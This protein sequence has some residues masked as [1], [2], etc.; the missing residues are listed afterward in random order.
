VTA[1]AHP[2]SPDELQRRAADPG[3]SVWV[4]AS[5]GTGKTKVLTDRVLRLLLARR[6][7]QP[8][9]PSSLLC[10]TFTRAAAAEMGNRL[11]AR[12]AK[13]ASTDDAELA[14]DLESLFGVA[15]GEDVMRRARRLFAIVLDAPGGLA[16]ET[17]HG[18]CQSLLRR[19]PLEVE[20]PPHFQVMEERD[21]AEAMAA[22]REEMLSRARVGTDSALAAA[23]KIVTEVANEDAFAEL[24]RA[25]A[26]ER[27]RL[28]GLAETYGSLG[29]AAAELRRR[30]G[31]A[32]DE[33]EAAIVA[34]AVRDPAF[35]VEAMRAA[36]A[37]LEGGSATDAASALAMA[38]FLAG[39]E[40][41]RVQ[42]FSDWCRVF[43]TK[44]GMPRKTPCTKA[45]EQEAPGTL[46]AMA[47]EA[48][49]LVAV[50]D[51]RR[52]ARTA[53]AT[54]ALLILAETQLDLYRRHKEARA[55]LDYDDLILHAVRMLTRSAPAWVHYKLDQGIDH[56]LIDEAQDTNPEQWAVVDALTREFFA[57]RGARDESI[58]TVFAV[59]DT[60]QSIFGFQRADPAAFPA[61]RARFARSVTD[62][63]G[64]WEP[65][66]LATSFRSTSAVL[67]AV[68]A[69]FAT[70][71]AAHGVAEPGETIQHDAAREGAG[72]SVELW[73]VIEPRP[74]EDVPS[75]LPPTRRFAADDPQA[76]LAELLAHR[77]RAML[78]GERLASRGDA[79][80]P[81]DILVLVRRRT[82]FVEMLVRALKA[83]A[84]P[85]AGSD[86]M[87]LTEQM[88]V[89]DLL[90]L[91]YALLL[92]EDN[93][94]LATVLKGPL[95]GLDE[96]DLFALA[97]NRT[98]S[99]WEALRARSIEEPFA[100]AWNTLI[101]LMALADRVP[102]H[103]LYA[104]ILSEGGKARLLA[105]LG[106][107]AED[108]IDEFIALT[109]AHERLHPPSLQGFLAWVEQGGDDIKRDLDTESGAV[110]IMTVH[111]A[112]G[113]EAPIVILADTTQVPRHMG[114]HL[115]W[116]GPPGAEVPLW[117]PRAEDLDPVGRDARDADDR[118][119]RREY[120]RLLYVAMT[121]AA[122]RLI[123][124]GWKTRREAPEGNWYD[125]VRAGLESLSDAVT[126]EDPFLVREGLTAG[127][128]IVRL[129]QEQ[130][131]E[132]ERRQAPASPRASGPVPDYLRRPPAA[133]PRPSRPLAPSRPEGVEPPVRS[134]FGADGGRRYRRGRVIHR[135]LELLPE[136][137][138]RRRTVA[139]RK[140]LARPRWGLEPN[141]R[142]EIAEEVT[143]V[144][145]ETGFAHLFGAGSRAEVP[146]V[147]TIGTHAVSGQID[148]ILVTRRTVT[149]VDFKSDRPAPADP[150]Q[151]PAYYMRQMAAYRALLAEVYPSRTV[152]C[153]LLWTDG[154][155]LM[156]L[157]DAMLDDAL[158]HLM[159]A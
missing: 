55:L 81:G 157:P 76:R 15:P 148:R 138:S 101:E 3:A 152:T 140:F 33:S 38:P 131:G 141:Q 56:V 45:V 37:A 85:V 39:D 4:A 159:A 144:L 107:E 5:A 68:D 103:D 30:M 73:P 60:K 93:L 71:G 24:M 1:P 7:D 8:V 22:A 65:L 150:A 106:A 95:I 92:P 44:E 9:R 19:F 62:A 133:E 91:G 27:S 13:W 120:R 6:E 126:I 151:A 132:P 40:T 64:R 94:T 121:R 89:M 111:G 136:L 29:G 42:L 34:A 61:M 53:A 10:L 50:N 26:R 127:Q 16:I 145:N 105:R 123:V 100:A 114:P 70:A 2:R 88:A 74:R 137:P 49:R 139:L 97:W 67:R 86:R 12:L 96:D 146:V 87:V 84:V 52:A 142:V 75:W 129:E 118:A 69:A 57:G 54:E 17:I 23:L 66:A 125:L 18:F 158:S 102:P 51:R 113:L 35:A 41:Q 59:G 25:L 58:R 82:P 79:I 112:K 43:L 63:N 122:D 124:C 147:G 109:L 99:L 134:P 108:P 149:I 77:I 135:L 32:P 47:E 28:A 46:A 36:L 110:R 115:H 119:R 83:A 156:V 98:G 116:I 31:L 154:P 20:V 14:R 117:A 11:A 153:A 21:A 90:A 80:R 130:I 104:R 143:R 128:E 48:E 155:N 78:D 72:G